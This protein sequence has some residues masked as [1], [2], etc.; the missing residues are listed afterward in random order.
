MY[1]L[2]GYLLLRDSLIFT[3]IEGCFRG[4]VA[5]TAPIRLIGGTYSPIEYA[6][7]TAITHSRIQNVTFTHLSYFPDV[8]GHYCLI[9]SLSG[10]Q[11][12]VH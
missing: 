4:K 1:S 7:T 11:L 5:K 10:V 9:K 8:C 3:A 6:E 2:I 12:S